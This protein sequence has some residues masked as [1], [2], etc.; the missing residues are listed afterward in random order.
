[1]P[2][3]PVELVRGAVPDPQEL[4]HR[5]PAKA[6]SPAL[7]A[8]GPSASQLNDF[9]ELLVARIQGDATP[10]QADACGICWPGCKPIPKADRF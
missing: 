2:R 10:E 6:E 4:R 7:P 5:S 8:L 9:R 3:A 1:M